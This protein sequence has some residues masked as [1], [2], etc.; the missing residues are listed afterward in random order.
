MLSEFPLGP[1]TNSPTTHGPGRMLAAQTEALCSSF[2]HDPRSFGS[3]ENQ[4]LCKG[5]KQSIK[6]WGNGPRG[7]RFANAKVRRRRN[8]ALIRRM[9]PTQNTPFGR[10]S[11]CMMHN[12]TRA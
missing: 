4:G 2:S 5:G 3:K 11:Y 9:R 10:V 12:H 6:P 8:W 1:H 7:A